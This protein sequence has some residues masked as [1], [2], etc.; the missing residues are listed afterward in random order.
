[1]EMLL[2]IT[3]VKQGLGVTCC[4]DHRF[5]SPICSPRLCSGVIYSHIPQSVFYYLLVFAAVVAHF[6]H[7]VG[8]IINPSSLSS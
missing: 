6:A 2:S 3:A 7:R 8:G 4:S 1:M 5:S